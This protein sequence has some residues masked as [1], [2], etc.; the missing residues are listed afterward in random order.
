MNETNLCEKAQLL[1]TQSLIADDEKSPTKAEL[2]NDRILAGH[3]K[4]Y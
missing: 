2:R 4:V 1:S 3:F